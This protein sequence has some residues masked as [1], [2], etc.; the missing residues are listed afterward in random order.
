MFGCEHQI[1]GAEEGVGPGGEDL[2]VGIADR[3][4]RRS[5]GGPADPV[6]LH[7]LDLVRPVQNIEVLE[8]PVRVGGDPHHPLPQAF[9]EDREV[10]ALA[11]AVGRHF[12]V[13]QHRPQPGTPVHQR[14]GPVDQPVAVDDVRA[15]TGGQLRPLPAVV[16]S[17]CTAVEFGDQLADAPGLVELRVEPGVV[18]L[19]EDPLR[20]GVEVDVGGGKAA[21][22]IVPEPESAQLAAEVGDV[23][24]GARARMG[25]GLNRILLGGQAE[26]VETQGVQ[27]IA[28]RHPEEARVDVG[29]D[30]AQRVPD[31]QA[32]TGGVGEHVLDEHL[33]G[34]DGA[35]VGGRQRADRVGHVEGAPPLPVV[36]PVRL[37]AAGQLRGVAVPRDVGIGAVRGGSRRFGHARQG[38]GA[39]HRPTTP[40]QRGWNPRLATARYRLRRR[41]V[42]GWFQ[43]GSIGVRAAAGL[44]RWGSDSGPHSATPAAQ[45]CE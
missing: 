24:I 9:P 22:L 37:D 32:L 38:I 1:G 21:A 14:V 16:R 23:G 3:E 12:L 41:A 30:I 39:P 10:T 40:E 29:R 17:S 36:L 26:R 18:D 2:D 43:V 25:T 19:Q 33:V 27:N 11:A 8:Q 31:V 20:P 34:R 6:A 28:S 7:G 5:P 45:P 44:V 35:A 42:R 15:L 13:G 4:Q